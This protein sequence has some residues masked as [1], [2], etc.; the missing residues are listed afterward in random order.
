MR[1]FLGF[2][3][4]KVLGLCFQIQTS[5]LHRCIRNTHLYRYGFIFRSLEREIQSGA[6]ARCLFGSLSNLVAYESAHCIG[7]FIEHC[8]EINRHISPGLILL[9][10]FRFGDYPAFNA[11]FIV[12]GYRCIGDS[13][14]LSLPIS[15]VEKDMA[16]AIFGEHITLESHT[17]GSCNFGLYVVIFQHNGVVARRSHLFVVAECR[18]IARF[19]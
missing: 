13:P 4:S 11:P 1:T 7:L 6:F 17:F 16:L 14:A 18:A 3:E 5:I 9:N 8:R 15:Y 10:V 2:V 19:P 12:V